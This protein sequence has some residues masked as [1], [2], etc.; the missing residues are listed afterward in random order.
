LA[1]VL[2]DIAVRTGKRQQ[3]IYYGFQAFFI[4]LGYANIAITIAIVHI[5]TG[6]VG[7]APSRAELIARSPTP[8][9]ALFGIRIHAA[10]VPAILILITIIIF[11]RFY[12]LTPDKVAA[13]KAKLEELGI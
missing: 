13:N 6:F 11:W 9:L 2:D 8:E 3:G 4:R 5:L 10:I 7:G 1:D 12:K